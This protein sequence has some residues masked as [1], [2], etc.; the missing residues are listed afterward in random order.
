MIARGLALALALVSAGCLK[1]S[2]A[3]CSDGIV[4]PSGQVCDEAR[5]SCVDP[6][7]LTA[8]DG[9][10]DLSACTT[11]AIPDGVCS[12]GV[13]LPTG[14]GNG[15]VEPGELCD[16]GNTVSGDG[17]SADC[18]S[19][20]MC[21][22]GYVDATRGETCDDGNVKGHDGCS[23]VCS[24]EY[25]MWQSVGATPPIRSAASL[26][27]DP[28]RRVTVL[29][30]GT[31]IDA[32]DEVIDYDDTWEWDGRNWRNVSPILAPLGRSEAAMAYDPR[33]HR[34]V[35]FG[36][37]SD[38]F[39]ALGDTWEFDGVTW[40]RPPTTVA[41]PARAGASM[42]WDPALRAV[43]LFGGDNYNDLWAW[44]G[45][46]WQP[47]PATN[48]PAGRS[49]AG[50]VYDLAGNRLVMAGG[51][52]STQQTDAWSFDGTSWTQLDAVPA[53]A[54]NILF[55][56]TLLY[57]A[58]RQVVVG[59][60]DIEYTSGPDA[61]VARLGAYTLSGSSWQAGAPTD[62]GS[63]ILPV[64]IEG[65][66]YAYDIE[67]DQILEFG[68]TSF[69]GGSSILI[70]GPLGDPAPKWA[71]PATPVAA[72]GSAL[73]YDPERARVVAFGNSFNTSVTQ[74]WDGHGWLTAGGAEPSPRQASAMAWDGSSHRVLLFGGSD[75]SG[76]LADTW[77]WDGT[78]WSNVS[79][80]PANSPS[81]RANATMAYDP[82]RGRVVLC[83]GSPQAG[84]Y[85]NDTWEWDGTSWSPIPEANA[86][87][88]FSA[89]MTYDAALQRIL[90]VGSVVGI[91]IAHTWQYDGT[92]WTPLATTETPDRVGPVA[93]D[94]P[95]A[96]IVLVGDGANA[97]TWELDDDTWTQPQ[98]ASVTPPPTHGAFA[99]YDVAWSH[100]LQTGGS[101]NIWLASY[102]GPD[103][104]VCG[105][106]VDMDGDG[107]V[108]CDDEDCAA[109][110]ARCGNGVC[111]E[112]ENDRL[113]PA[114]CAATT[115]VC[116][117]AYCAPTE[118]VATCPAD[119]AP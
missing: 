56:S 41:P 10:A 22:D 89:E 12:G 96:H 60:F 85:L 107:R 82:G 9:M 48:P 75:S 108:G 63:T 24:T 67:R 35:L 55:L 73:A 80:A 20:E 83:G 16:D 93:F 28:L 47:V 3:Q 84:V 52:Y 117:D 36:G 94:D 54:S 100:V 110:C 87:T 38:A 65:T 86:P 45:A 71:Y 62:D 7:Q 46:T 50:L 49:G 59:L 103:E 42:A 4:C 66:A 29:F 1:D 102:A 116:G 31:T 40:R 25:W 90:M 78:Q 69:G 113:C 21:G 43:V 5:Q 112:V 44:D 51:T 14:C 30:G 61:G 57:D 33:R 92:S 8:C 53:A 74:E 37:T 79:P 23:S 109:V 91:G 115:A 39:G 97:S 11:T 77:A 27:Y 72:V 81:P 76:A 19:R 64:L 2:L 98:G 95:R 26:V 58:R 18:Q 118:T 119:C 34:V 32:N 104:E 105:A 68:G 99:V 13:C 111:D 17:C 106:G 114:D 70:D 15:V 6:Q 101:P 88:A